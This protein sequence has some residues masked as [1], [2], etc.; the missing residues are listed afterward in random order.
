MAFLKEIARFLIGLLVP[1]IMIVIGGSVIGFAITS[2]H[3]TLLV[4][5]L[6]ILGA[7]VIWGAFLLYY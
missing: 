1:I 5:G 7:G 2:E 6:C 4:V 3:S